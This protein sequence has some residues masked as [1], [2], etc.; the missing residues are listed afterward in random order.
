MN[1]TTI[2][3]L[4]GA[5]LLGAARLPAAAQTVNFDDLTHP[6]NGVGAARTAYTQ[7]GFTLLRIPDPADPASYGNHFHTTAGLGTP[8]LPNTTAAEFF[9]DDGAPIRYY[10]GNYV[11]TGAGNYAV[12]TQTPFNLVSLN[13][14]EINGAF[15]L[16]AANGQTQ[17]LDHAGIYHFGAAF[18]GILEF[19]HDYNG[20]TD[21]D[22][23][24]DDIAFRPTLF[25]TVS[26]HITVAGTTFAP[27]AVTVEVRVPGTTTALQTLS[28]APESGG[29]FTLTHLPDSVY[30]LAFKGANTLRLVIPNVSLIGGDATGLAVA[31]P[32]GDANG[33]NVVD[34]G[35][36]G[37]LVNAYNGDANVPGSGY[38]ARADFDG[39]G[40]IDIGDFG[41]MV[42]NYNAAGAP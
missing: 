32:G 1:Q 28:V 6:L 42:N 26:G 17:V 33:D 38:D 8:G 9:S 10:L 30:D 11:G 31:L 22:M 4:L 14:L 3:R 13:V 23:I 27:A 18:A 15:T 36:F 20:S 19:R 21:G 35:D 16:T 7:N 5:V 2:L 24:V 25:R 12:G 29:A 34:I 39:N 41:I 37:L 40:L